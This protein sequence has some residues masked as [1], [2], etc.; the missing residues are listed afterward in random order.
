MADPGNDSRET[1]EWFHDAR[2]KIDIEFRLVRRQDAPACFTKADAISIA[3]AP[4]G[5]R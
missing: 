4:A 3:V 1:S 5:N 2:A